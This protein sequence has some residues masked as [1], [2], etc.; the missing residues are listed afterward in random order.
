MEGGAG[1]APSTRSCRC[2][3]L[4]GHMCC[5]S[6][7]GG[8]ERHAARL[9]NLSYGL[10]TKSYQYAIIPPR[11]CKPDTGPDIE[12]AVYYLLSDTLLYCA[13]QGVQY[14]YSLHHAVLHAAVV[15]KEKSIYRYVLLVVVI[16]QHGGTAS[17][18]S[19]AKKKEAEGNRDG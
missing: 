19:T 10:R 12:M 1:A 2:G 7:P 4:P 13:L 15:W 16:C 5:R 11:S 9:T 14:G 6:S 3:T 17:A 8:G 18:C